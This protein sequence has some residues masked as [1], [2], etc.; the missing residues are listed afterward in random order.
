MDKEIFNQ[1]QADLE[2]FLPSPEMSSDALIRF[3]YTALERNYRQGRG[4]AKKEAI[5]VLEEAR[6]KEKHEVT[7]TYLQEQIRGKV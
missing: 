1:I 7:I 5:A 2:K 3:V 4:E 6:L